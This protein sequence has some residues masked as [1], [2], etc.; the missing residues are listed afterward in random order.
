MKNYYYFLGVEEN[1]GDEE[2]RKAYRKLSVKYHPDKNENDEFFAR[3]FMEIQEAYDILADAEKRR[4]YDENLSHQQRSYRPTLPPAIKS[5]SA[6]KIRAQKGEEIIIKW[7]TNNA[8]IV[9]IIPFGLEK[10]YGERAFKIT[11]FKNGEFQLL[12][13]ATNSLLNKTVVRGI[14]ITE[15]FENDAEKFR[16]D[17]EELFKPQTPSRSNPGGQ[18]RII[19]I[20][21]AVL[22]LLI[23]VL[24][25]F[26]TFSS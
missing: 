15:V 19:R 16:N 22:F 11:E 2:I 4:I 6:N 12:L 1:A 26:K 24:L 20:V 25:L 3:R 13:H 18:P 9:K 23:A 8:D 10:G 21:M 17:V 14:T 7:Q 5:F